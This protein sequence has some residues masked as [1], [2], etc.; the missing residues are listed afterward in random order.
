MDNNPHAEP[1]EEILSKNIAGA[2]TKWLNKHPQYTPISI[3][4]EVESNG[5]KSAVVYYEVS[6]RNTK[7]ISAPPTNQ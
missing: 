2:V 4:H 7:S 6:Q 3:L 5:L 1:P